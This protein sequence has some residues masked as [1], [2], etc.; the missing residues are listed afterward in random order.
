MTKPIDYSP[1][2]DELVMRAEKWLNSI[3]C[4]VVIRDPFR[5]MNSEQPDAI[6][7]KPGNDCISILIECKVNRADFL[8]DKN[9]PFRKRPSLGMGDWRFFFAPR[10]VITV[11][12]LPANWGLIEVTPKLCV[13]V[14]GV[15]KQPGE[16][17]HY[18]FRNANKRAEN[19]MMLSALRRL[20]IRNKFDEIYE[21][22][23]EYEPIVQMTSTGT[24]PDKAQSV[25]MANKILSLQVVQNAG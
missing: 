17:V 9:K 7:W 20:Q 21:P 8:K 25:K 22:L 6:G 23:S 10:G 1:T 16:W 2:H 3:G 11:D 15:P 4:N 18:P 24:K 5:T 13:K 19:R 12:D 14:H